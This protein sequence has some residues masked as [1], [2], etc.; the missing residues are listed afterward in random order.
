[1]SALNTMQAPL[2]GPGLTRT[3]T[4]G[5]Q[6]IVQMQP[7]EIRRVER[8]AME[9]A[10]MLGDLAFYGWGAGKNRIEGPAWPLTKSLMRVYG[11]CSLDM[12]PVQ[13]LP[14]AWVMTA[15]AVDHETGFS[16][17]R[18]FRQSKTWEVRG[19]FDSARKEDI[20]FQ[21]GQSK[22]LRNVA[23]AFLPDWL[24]ARALD[25]A[26]GNVRGQI[27]DA[28]AKHGQAAVVAKALTR[29]KNVGVDEPRVLAAMGRKHRDALTVEDLVIIAGGI[30]AIE[31][32]AD[33][34]DEVFPLPQAP[35][36]SNTSRLS[37]AIGFTPDPVP[38]ADQPSDPGP[39]P[40][41]P[42]P[43]DANDGF[44]PSDLK[45]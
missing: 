36:K 44:D 11:N 8:L 24:V 26:K 22:A 13:D 45:F 43:S 35:A 10:G 31:T 38:P 21:I 32:K 25:T 15:R 40:T 14:D 33:T 6:A 29:C 12:E 3:T 27:E 23:L 41:E 20:R 4:A 18:Q 2:P 19:N 9:E 42:E 34:A 5:T 16:I 28:I 30:R 37:E 1:M 17:C 39:D 7:R